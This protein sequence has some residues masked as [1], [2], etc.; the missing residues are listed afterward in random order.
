MGKTMIITELSKN[1]LEYFKGFDPFEYTERKDFE[2]SLVLGA[3]IDDGEGNVPAGILLGMEKENDLVILWL[4]T[5]GPFRRRGVS[6]KLLSNAFEYAK[7]EKFERLAAIF[8]AEYSR[9]VICVGEREF[10]THHG[11]STV[12]ENIMS[13]E[14]SEYEK[15]TEE[16][17][18]N[19]GEELAKINLFGSIDPVS[20]TED[21]EKSEGEPE[22]LEAKHKDWKVREVSVQE[23]S[24]VVAMKTP[25]GQYYANEL[26]RHVEA[27][28]IN[29]IGNLSL[30][31]FRE[32]IKT[33]LKNDHSGYMEDPMSVPFSYFD[34]DLSSFYSDKS[35]VTGL[36]LMH[37]EAPI[38]TIIVELFF[39]EGGDTMKLLSLLAYGIVKALEKYSVTTIIRIPDEE[40]IHK[41]LVDKIFN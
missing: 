5:A 16:P 32:M 7:K 8:P 15:L 24:D 11:F 14:V 12:G 33:C 25:T 10:F 30:S 31:K 41:P 35:G 34:P 20:Y 21:E 6:E 17:D 40:E 39:V 27:G 4:F 29:N 38:D 28:A 18:I 9:E 23:L 22:I 36:F 26:A 13:V 37:Y 3:L 1:K 19:Y 2:L